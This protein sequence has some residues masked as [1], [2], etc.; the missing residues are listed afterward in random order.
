MAG[1]PFSVPADEVRTLFAPHGE[2]EELF[3]HDCLEEEPRFKERGLEWMT[4]RVFQIS[5]SRK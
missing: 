3:V 5:H 2:I 4:E 1:P